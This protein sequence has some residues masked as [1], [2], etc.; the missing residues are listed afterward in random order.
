MCYAYMA[1]FKKWNA[2]ALFGKHR[3]RLGATKHFF[4]EIHVHVQKK[5]AKK[6]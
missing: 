6:V 1:K 2:V 3:P 4:K 5:F